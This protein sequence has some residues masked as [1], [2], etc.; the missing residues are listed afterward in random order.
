MGDLG[1]RRRGVRGEWSS[2]VHD[3][4]GSEK[5]HRSVLSDRAA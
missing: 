5:D 3:D 2:I 4:N 1:Q